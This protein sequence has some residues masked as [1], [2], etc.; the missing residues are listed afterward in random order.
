MESMRPGNETYPWAK[1]TTC[2]KPIKIILVDDHVIVRQALRTLLAAERDMKV[3]AEADDGR[4]ALRL[5]QELKPQVVIMDISMPNLNGIE[6]T[7]QILSE[8]PEVKVIALSMHSDSLF[9]LN[10]L[11]AGTKG[12][13]QKDSAS[14]EELIKA[15]RTVVANKTYLSPG[16]SDIVINRCVS[17]C[18]NIPS[19]F[20]TL[21]VRERQVLQLLAEGNTTNQI[22]N[23]LHVC[24]KTVESHRKNIMTKVGIHNVAGLTKYA[25]CQGLTTL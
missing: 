11:K 14:V 9:V 24:L 23:S 17:R 18:N 5:V 8:S 12:Y 7:R 16:V 4:A 20:S 2:G 1:G 21:S 25:V 3:I 6:A 19:G 10:M 15:I 22:A 13:L